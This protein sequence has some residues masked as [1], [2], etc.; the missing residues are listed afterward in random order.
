MA[1]Q[2]V[3]LIALGLGMAV[4]LL[5]ASTAGAQ[6][7]SLT[8]QMASQNSSGISGVA[9]MTDSG[10]KVKV[11]V[12]ATGAGSGP[13]PLHI[14]EGSCAQ[15]NPTPQFSLSPVT[16]GTS[17]TDVDTSLQALTSTPHAI[18]M[19]KSAEELSV[20][21]ACADVKLGTALPGTGTGDSPIGL[22]GIALGLLLVGLGSV[23]RLRAR[24]R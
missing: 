23:R 1:R 13:Q 16:N 17:T 11:D 8:V 24:V 14:H 2:P 7:Q 15:L 10:G 19:H 3:F 9:T 21:V 20:Y 6:G 18:H 22:L 12:R 5:T 4:A